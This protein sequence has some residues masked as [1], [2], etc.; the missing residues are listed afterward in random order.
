MPTSAS[1]LPTAFVPHG[2]GPWPVLRLPMLA[3]AEAESLAGYMRSI[4]QVSPAP[5]ALLVVSAHWEARVPTVNTGA[6]PP[7]LYDYGGFP[8]E[9]YRLRWPAP[10]DPVLAAEVADRLAAAGFRPEREDHRG[11][12]H[13]TFIPL[14]LAYPKAEIPVVQLSLVQGLDPAE[15]LALGRALAPLRAQGVYVLG[16]GNSF[17]DLRAFF[18][19]DAAAAAASREFDAWLAETVALP[20][21]EREA[22]LER[23]EQAPAARRS[24]PRE[25]HLLPL[26][27]VAGAAGEERGRVQW[28][29]TMGGMTVSAHHFG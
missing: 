14:M 5:R 4:G 19:G 12:D 8:P 16:S 23:W 18:R 9:A 10:G 21:A 6:A 27:V 25:E 29:G 17:H 11:Y 2:G 26:M 13:G 1:P 3:E 24:H 28:S 22:R 20:A 15:H 7:M